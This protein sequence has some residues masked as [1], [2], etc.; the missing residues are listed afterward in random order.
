M[1]YPLFILFILALTSC[2]NKSE[3]GI[4]GRYN[5]AT[6]KIREGFKDVNTTS[7]SLLLNDD[8]TFVF[9]TKKKKIKGNW[10]AQDFRG[11]TLIEFYFDDYDFDTQ[12]NVNSEN[13]NL[14]ILNAH[15]FLDENIEAIAFKKIK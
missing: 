14:D 13:N 5:V 15:H 7:Y 10:K 11:E 8:K 1:K 4:I 6:Y 9:N 3:K 12:G 2:L